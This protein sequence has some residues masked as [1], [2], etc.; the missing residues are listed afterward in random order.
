MSGPHHDRVRRIAGM[1]RSGRFTFA[2]GCRF[3]LHPGHAPRTP[4]NRKARRK[5]NAERRRYHRR[6]L[7]GCGARRVTAR[8]PF[9]VPPAVLAAATERHRSAPVRALPGTGLCRN[10]RYPS[11][12]VLQCSGSPS[13]RGRVM[14]PAGRFGPEPP[15]SAA[16]EAAPAGTAPAPTGRGHRP[17]SLW[18]ECANHVSIYVTNVN[19]KVTQEILLLPIAGE[20]KFFTFP[21]PLCGRGCRSRQRTTAPSS[22][23]CGG[24]GERSEP[25]GAPSLRLFAFIKQSSMRAPLPPPSAV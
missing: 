14:V 24:G 19:R 20:V 13:T 21:S 17:A 25:E 22:P 23:A 15:G 18:A 16:D 10:G 11:P 7:A 9:G 6:N 4:T 2:P 1:E 8:T 12:A 3:P 5:R